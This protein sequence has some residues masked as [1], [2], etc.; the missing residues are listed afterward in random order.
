MVN[1]GEAEPMNT[2]VSLPV[3]QTVMDTFAFALSKFPSLFVLT[4]VAAIITEPLTFL[5]LQ[6]TGAFAGLASLAQP[7]VSTERFIASLPNSGPGLLIVLMGVLFFLALI[8][9]PIIRHITHG[10]RLWLIRINSRT[11]HYML[12]QLPVLLILVGIILLWLD[13]AAMKFLLWLP[14]L[15]VLSY[16]GARL[17][18]VPVDAIVSG[19]VNIRNGLSLSRNNG[20]RLLL[21]I[22]A[23]GLPILIVGLVAMD[24]VLQLYSADQDPLATASEL[25]ASYIFDGGPGQILELYG[26][27]FSRPAFIAANMIVFLFLAIA[28]GALL[29]A[30]AIAYCKLTKGH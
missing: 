11:F 18:L 20:L 27:I 9:V 29:S 8:T 16:F 22:L 26:H 25:D 1:V 5:S 23:V 10:E 28:A 19:S 14:V 3:F 6:F 13:A 17:S 15:I 30:P 2:R 12:S 24:A 21:I 7:G 4:F